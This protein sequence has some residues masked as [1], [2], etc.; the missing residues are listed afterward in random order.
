MAWHP[1]IYTKQD[2]L[3]AME[4]T[5]SVKALARYLGCSYPHAKRYLKM[6]TDEETGKTFFEL[7]KNQQGKG[8]KKHLGGKYST[9]PLTDIL[10]GK[11]DV[12]NYAPEKL[13][14]KLIE[15]GYLVEECSRCGYHERRLSDDKA[16]L[17][18]SFKNK[19]NKDWKKENLEMLCYNC[20]FIYINNIWSEEQLG[21]METYEDQKGKHNQVDIE[22]EF[23]VDK[24]HIEHL[25]ELGLW[26]EQS[27]GLDDIFVN[28]V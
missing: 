23:K 9:A 15:D 12:S 13:K 24:A 16:P 11:A 3:V 2:L 4:R 17:I 6:F 5:K 28:K 10:E 14:I 1:K 22:S 26:E 20:Y 8:I 27:D 7:H 25:K 18:L 19:N 21:K